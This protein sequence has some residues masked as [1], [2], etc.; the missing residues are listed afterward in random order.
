MAKQSFIFMSALLCM[1]CTLTKLHSIQ[2][3]RPAQQKNQT[4]QPS[5]KTSASLAHKGLQPI[6][7]SGKLFIERKFGDKKRF[8]CVG[9]SAAKLQAIT[10]KNRS[11]CCGFVVLFSYPCT[12]IMV[13]NNVKL[14]TSS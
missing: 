14:S 3:R 6:W 12:S 5:L 2:S 7:H 8:S 10:N 11:D 9:A 13:R 4:P 1:L